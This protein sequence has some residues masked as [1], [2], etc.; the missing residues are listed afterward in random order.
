MSGMVI[1]FGLNNFSLKDPQK[2]YAEKLHSVNF[3]QGNYNGA[4]QSLT[5]GS[6]GLELWSPNDSS[7][8]TLERFLD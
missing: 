6:T 8:D 2:P 3:V 4:P 1:T 5:E 7:K